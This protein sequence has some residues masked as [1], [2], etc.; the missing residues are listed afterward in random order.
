MGLCMY[1]IIFLEESQWPFDTTDFPLSSFLPHAYAT[2]DPALH[3]QNRTHA[4]RV[5][6]FSGEAG[7]VFVHARAVRPLRCPFD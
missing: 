4:R 2:L 6:D 7:G 1:F 3:R 5:G